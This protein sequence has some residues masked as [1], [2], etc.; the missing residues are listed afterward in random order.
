VAE[1]SG[2]ERRTGERR[3]GAD[4]R[5]GRPRVLE[6]PAVLFVRVDGTLRARLLAIAT[7]EDRRP[8]EVHRELLDLALRVRER[9]LNS[10]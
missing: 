1:W 10:D 7:R 9:R 2:V 4:R 3:A 6:Q 8:S 5:R